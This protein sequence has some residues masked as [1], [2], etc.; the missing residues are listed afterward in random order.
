MSITT[1]TQTGIG[2]LF[3][4]ITQTQTGSSYI[5]NLILPNEI[6]NFRTTTY[7]NIAP[8]Q[9]SSFDN[10]NH[11][12]IFGFKYSSYFANMDSNPLL[13]HIMETATLDVSYI[14]AGAKNYIFSAKCNVLGFIHK[15]KFNVYVD[16]QPYLNFT[17][18]SPFVNFKVCNVTN[19]EEIGIIARGYLDDGTNLI[20]PTYGTFTFVN[21]EQ[22]G[23]SDIINTTSQY[24]LS[25]S[26]IINTTL[27]YQ[28]GMVNILNLSS[29][30]QFG[31]ADILN[32]TPQEQFG[33]AD[34]LNITPQE[35]FGI[36]DISFIP[37]Q[38]QLGRADVLNTTPQEQFG[39]ADILNIIPQEQSGMSNI[40]V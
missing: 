13:A 31:E 35:Q 27:Q 9:S 12:L 8:C 10:F 25:M 32:I 7:Y 36:A 5:V 38:Y 33:V 6:K 26:D 23:M 11:E 3:Y 2:R 24:Q 15:Y 37:G 39:E 18:S 16:G 19:V 40:T 21:K 4:T 14:D 20:F 29:Q 22:Y 34:I 28:S 17:S 30:E 1:Q